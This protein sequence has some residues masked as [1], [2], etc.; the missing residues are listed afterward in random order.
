M[1]TIKEVRQAVQDRFKAYEAG[2]PAGVL[3][4]YDEDFDYWDMQSSGRIRERG[5]LAAHLGEF[6]RTYDIR[7]VLLEEHR[8]EGQDAAI[9]L[10]NCA[11][12][13]RSPDGA[14]GANLAFQRGMN[15]LQLRDGLIARDESYM[16]LAAISRLVN[17]PAVA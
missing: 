10:W 5:A 14:P 7:Y 8:L 9:V 13:R 6:L 4:L 17:E 15:L 1:M 2:D 3:A 16:D 11:I 12:R